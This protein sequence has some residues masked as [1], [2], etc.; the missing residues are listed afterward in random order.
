M[1]SASS[2]EATT[3]A[4][5]FQ[6]QDS[7]PDENG[8][9]PLSTIAAIRLP[10]AAGRKDEGRCD[11]RVG[12]LA[13]TPRP[14][15]AGRTC[16]AS[17]GGWRGWRNSTPRKHRPGR[18]HRRN[19]PARRNRSSEPPTRL[20]CRIR[21]RPA[22]CRSRSVSGGRRRNV[23]RS[24]GALAQ[25]RDQR[26]GAR[27][28]GGIAV[29]AHVPRQGVTSGLR[30]LPAIGASSPGR[31]DSAGRAASLLRGSSAIKASSKHGYSAILC[32]C[33]RSR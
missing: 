12:V 18:A 11:Q 23:P 7:T 30:V 17:S 1:P 13:S 14:A 2:S 26:A 15:R 3:P 25:P 28:H 27:D 24:G 10:G 19:R 9:W 31:G 29:R 16:R 33:Q 6:S 4:S 5:M 21:N 22:S 32:C 8:Q 20:G